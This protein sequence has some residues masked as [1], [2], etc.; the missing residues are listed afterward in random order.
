[1]VG[2]CHSLVYDV[3]CMAMDG[4]TYNGGH[5]LVY[6]YRIVSVGGDNNGLVV[7]YTFILITR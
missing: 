3:V 5:S 6:L 4:I 2:G 1:M 7:S